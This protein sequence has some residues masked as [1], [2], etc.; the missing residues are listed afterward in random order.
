MCQKK[1][2]GDLKTHGMTVSIKARDAEGGACAGE[3]GYGEWGVECL[4]GTRSSS[5][6][7][8]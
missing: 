5:A 7:D 2:R 3:A 1:R 8:C 4:L 6:R